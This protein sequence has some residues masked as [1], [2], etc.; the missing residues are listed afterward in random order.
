MKILASTS[1][2]PRPM[3]IINIDHFDPVTLEDIGDTESYD[4]D[5]WAAC[6]AWLRAH[7]YTDDAMFSDDWSINKTGVYIEHI[8]SPR[9]ETDDPT[10]IAELEAANR[11]YGPQPDAADVNVQNIFKKGQAKMQNNLDPIYEV[12]FALMDVSDA[13][14]ISQL[15]HEDLAKLDQAIE[16]F[17]EAGTLV[18]Q[19]VASVC[20]PN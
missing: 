19:V 9:A 3:H 2:S 10:W 8:P 13:N 20:S 6:E 1:R 18:D 5:S 16:L 11:K 15:S 12:V 7:G 14:G 17:K 4:F